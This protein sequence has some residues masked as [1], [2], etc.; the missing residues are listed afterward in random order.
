MVEDVETDHTPLYTAHLRISSPP[1]TKT[2]AITAELMPQI[3]EPFIFEKRLEAA[4]KLSRLSPVALFHGNRTYNVM[5]KTISDSNG[6][7][8]RTLA[9]AYDGKYEFWI[10][11]ENKTNRTATTMSLKSK[12]VLEITLDRMVLVSNDSISQIKNCGIPSDMKLSEIAI[13]QLKRFYDESKHGYVPLFVSSEYTVRATN[14]I[15]GSWGHPLE[16][17]KLYEKG[18]RSEKRPVIYSVPRRMRMNKDQN[19]HKN[20][21]HRVLRPKKKATSKKLSKEHRTIANRPK[22]D[23]PHENTLEKMCENCEPDE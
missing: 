9:R 12:H 23:K 14:V 21:W 4:R 16:H 13:T 1:R 17:C 3:L 6:I 5:L 2:N 8:D 7:N 22:T 20:E 15:T 18:L 11:L 19:P 10:L